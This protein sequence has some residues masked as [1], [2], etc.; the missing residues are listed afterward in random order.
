MNRIRALY[1]P[2]GADEPMLG[3]YVIVY[4]RFG[5]A[6]VTHQTAH[7][8]ERQLVRF[9]PPRWMVFND[10]AGSRFRVRTRDILR[11]MESTVAQ[12]AN[13]R[14]L[15]RAERKEAKADRRP[16]EDDD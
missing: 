11:M 5:W 9:W 10:C 16:W 14:Q 8:I 15:D 2:E 6:R 4:G 7:A 13:D 3:D 12:R 1:E